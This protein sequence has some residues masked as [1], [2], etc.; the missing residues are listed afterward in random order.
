[1]G[2][3]GGLNGILLKH[4][5]VLKRQKNGSPAAQ[6]VNGHNLDIATAVLVAR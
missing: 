5:A 3:L 4:W 1:M 6:S 2:S